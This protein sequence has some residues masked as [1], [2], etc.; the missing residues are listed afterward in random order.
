M[1]GIRG[2]ALVSLD[3][4]FDEPEPQFLVF[5]TIQW[6]L[7]RRQDYDYYLLV[8]DDIEVPA[9]VLSNVIAFDQV[10]MVNEVLHPNRIELENGVAYNTDFRTSGQ[11]TT[12]RKLFCGRQLAVNAN[13]HAAVFVLSAPTFNYCGDH[14]DLTLR[15]RLR[16]GEFRGG[17]MAS[18]FANFLSPVSLYRPYDDLTFHYVVHQDKFE[19][20]LT[21]YHK[22]SRIAHS[23]LPLPLV[24]TIKRLKRRVSG[25]AES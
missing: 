13:P 6:M 20:T 16:I 17:M 10:S 23:L 5:D 22:L 3:V 2:N 7:E 12:Q 21:T 1:C 15:G 8:E 14:A 25:E 9:E 19:P 18:A 24:D 4:E 11:W